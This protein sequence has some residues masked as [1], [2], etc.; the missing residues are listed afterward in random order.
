M[1]NLFCFEQNK[2]HELF[3]KCDLLARD[4]CSGSPLPSALSDCIHCM[5]WLRSTCKWNKALLPSVLLSSHR[6]KVH[7][8]RYIAAGPAALK[9]FLF[10]SEQSR[11]VVQ[12]CGNAPTNS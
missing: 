8:V 7:H 12:S 9:C 6:N 4:M 11:T 2:G 10:T 3:T 1:A 5:A